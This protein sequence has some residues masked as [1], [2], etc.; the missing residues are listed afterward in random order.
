MFSICKFTIAT[1]LFSNAFASGT[2]SSKKS[3][4][5]SEALDYLEGLRIRDK[6]ETNKET[7][8]AVIQNIKTAWN[9]IM[10]DGNNLK[11]DNICDNK[12]NQLETWCNDPYIRKM[13]RNAQTFTNPPKAT[14]T[15]RN[16]AMDYNEYAFGKLLNDLKSLKNETDKTNK[17]VELKN[18]LKGLFWILAQEYDLSIIKIDSNFIKGIKTKGPLAILQG[19]SKAI[20][21]NDFNAIL[22][23]LSD[24]IQ[25]ET[26]GDWKLFEWL[27]VSYRLS[28]ITGKEESFKNIKSKLLE[29]LKD[30]KTLK[31]FPQTENCL[32]P[33]R[34]LY[35][36][37]ETIKIDS[38]EKEL[39]FTKNP[40]FNDLFVAGYE[41][42]IKQQNFEIN[43]NFE[44]IVRDL[45]IF[46]W[47]SIL[48][49]NEIQ[50]GI[51]E[52]YGK[53][54]KKASL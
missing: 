23:K 10:K 29:K 51:I 17:I 14:N 49:S 26:I 43:N 41:K 40:K 34:A 37:D 25:L 9:E 20:T 4:T 46:S 7:T 6:D 15:K 3:S 22:I 39:L 1:I 24:D 16:I 2:I 11:Y 19:I 52:K 31:Y 47:F 32:L 45:E 12:G 38:N 27:I 18:Q 8:N 42:D 50:K 30:C 54:V 21:P 36:L 33:L 35:L 53:N 5:E 44:R 28:P 48:K 13:I